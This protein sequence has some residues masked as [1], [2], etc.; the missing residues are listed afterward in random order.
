MLS[1]NNFK[2]LLLSPVLLFGFENQKVLII[3]QQNINLPKLTSKLGFDSI[4]L[5]TSTTTK[6]FYIQQYEVNKKDFYPFALQLIKNKNLI[7][8]IDSEQWIEKYVVY[9]ED[10]ELFPVTKVSFNI[11]SQYCKSIKGRLPTEKEWVLAAIT[12]T[13]LGKFSDKYIIDNS[14]LPVDLSVRSSNG[15]FG[16][17]ANVWEYTI[18]P[19][20]N[21]H[22][23]KNK[24]I[25]KGGSYLNVE[26]K[27]FYNPR[28]RNFTLKED[29]NYEY[30]HIG[31]RC[32]FDK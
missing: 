16:M 12:E 2:I 29:I 10:D 5:Q 18:S 3:P 4:P 15:L 30:D 26:N 24:I 7:E 13:D 32:V 25:I 28:F 9:D 21:T 31:F 27:D 20:D 6:S 1:I 17:V 23:S 19:Y 11:A 22:N 14:L 8:N